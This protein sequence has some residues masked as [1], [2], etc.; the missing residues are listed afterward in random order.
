MSKNKKIFPT[1]KIEGNL[2]ED[3]VVSH[4][5][6]A[7]VRVS[8]LKENDFVLLECWL[9]KGECGGSYEPFI[10]KCYPC[11][12]VS[13]VVKY[14]FPVNNFYIEVEGKYRLILVNE[15][16]LEQ[17]DNNHFSEVYISYSSINI[18]G[19]QRINIY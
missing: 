16:D 9:D 5:N 2:T 11:M 10:W 7:H 1:E 4:G 17:E 15:G 18:E 6:F 13:S 19:F 12:D 3:I 14:S 8:G